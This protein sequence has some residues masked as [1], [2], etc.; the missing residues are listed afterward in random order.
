MSSPP[1]RR[2]FAVI[3]AAGRSRRMGTHKL[4]LPLAG[5]SVISRVVDALHRAGPIEVHVI[6]RRDDESLR[7]ELASLPVHPHLLDAD[8][9]DMRASV[10]RLLDLIT[11]E[12]QPAP[13]D[14]WLLCP[15]DHPV[16]SADVVRRLIVESAT[17][18]DSIGIPTSQDRRGHPTL[19]PWSLA[20]SVRDI[21]TGEGLNWLL[22]AHAARVREVEVDD[23]TILLD[24]DTPE[25]YE[26]ILAL[27]P[28][29]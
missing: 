1:S 19:F 10:E 13:S 4:L 22:R 24:L 29:T 18:P 21:P 20:S 25:D 9:P 23:P 7:S 5:R 8:T 28:P 15:A 12:R 27:I 16:L 11:A 17:A 26:R 14:A 3:P 6:L 2:L